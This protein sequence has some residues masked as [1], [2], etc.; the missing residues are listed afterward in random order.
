[1][2]S[3]INV[4][5]HVKKGGGLLGSVLGGILGA[6]AGAAT[7][8]A[9]SGPLAM[10]GAAI[11]GAGSG[12]A[13][14]GGI[15]RAINPGGVSKAGGVP[16]VQHAAENDPEVQSMQLEEAK[17]ALPS[18]PLPAG[19]KDVYAANFAKASEV[20]ASA[21]KPSL[22]GLPDSVRNPGGFTFGRA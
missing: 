15:D 21:R 11:G 18:A 13:A 19:E 6:I 9:G 12:M 22:F 8:G 2:I 10:A 5:P 4:Q 1:M 3:G 20:L 7:A 14:G 17:V 16:T